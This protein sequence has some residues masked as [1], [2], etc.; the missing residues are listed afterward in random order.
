M[1]SF[2]TKLNAKF[3]RPPIMP[4]QRECILFQPETKE[5]KGE[6]VWN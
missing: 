2:I 4:K 5:K 3:P 1:D 6:I